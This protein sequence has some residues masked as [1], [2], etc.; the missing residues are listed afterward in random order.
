LE[1]LRT[2]VSFSFFLKNSTFLLSLSPAVIIGIITYYQHYP[3]KNQKVLNINDCVL[4]YICV[5]IYIY[6]YLEEVWRKHS[7]FL[8]LM[9]THSWMNQIC[10]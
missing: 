10:S 9:S 4:I 3:H 7:I 6:R 1:S 8:I 2:P 5:F